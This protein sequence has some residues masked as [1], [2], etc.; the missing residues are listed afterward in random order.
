MAGREREREMAKG[1]K[2]QQKGE[3]CPKRG[4]KKN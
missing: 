3:P 4:G 1:K 2:V